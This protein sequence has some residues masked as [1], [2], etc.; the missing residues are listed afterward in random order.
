MSYVLFKGDQKTPPQGV[1]L[2][3]IYTASKIYIYKYIDSLSKNYKHENQ[4]PPGLV[5]LSNP[6]KGYGSTDSVP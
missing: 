4:T 2:F 1:Q 6:C 3:V 5:M